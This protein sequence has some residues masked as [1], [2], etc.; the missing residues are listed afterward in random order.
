MSDELSFE[1][2]RTNKNSES[3]LMIPSPLSQTIEVKRAIFPQPQNKHKISIK[4]VQT[5]CAAQPKFSVS[6]LLQKSTSLFPVGYFLKC[7]SSI[8]E[9]TD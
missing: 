2:S 3:I 1:V 4:L 8:I 6:K 5:A 7:Q 9:V